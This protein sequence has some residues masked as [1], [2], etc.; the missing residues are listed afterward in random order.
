MTTKEERDVARKLVLDL[1]PGEGRTVWSTWRSKHMQSTPTHGYLVS[2]KR[3]GM[4]LGFQPS[5]GLVATWLRLVRLLELGG[6]L[7]SPDCV[8]VWQDGGYWY[9]DA[10]V[11]F[12]MKETALEIAQEQDQK[13][14]WDL[15]E[16]KALT[17]PARKG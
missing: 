17:V 10:N 13:S 12:W 16:G 9:M 7:C 4:R 6:H 1:E 14:V 2:M 15:A 5:V 8:G 11:H 3:T